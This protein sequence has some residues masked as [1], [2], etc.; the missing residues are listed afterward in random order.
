M[1]SDFERLLWLYSMGVE[2]VA[3]RQ[4]KN[5]YTDQLKKK[6]NDSANQDDPLLKKSEENEYPDREIF[7]NEVYKK[8]INAIESVA[9]LEA[10]WRNALIDHFNIKKFWG[11]NKFNQINKPNILIIH[12]PPNI[13]DFAQYSFLDGK[14]KLIIIK[15]LKIFIIQ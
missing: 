12:E 3:T 14:K 10:Y 15:V 8:N 11:Y 2:D 7:L 4:P 1:R 5:Y 13:R 6:I 9:S